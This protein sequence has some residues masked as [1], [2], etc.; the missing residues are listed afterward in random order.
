M[1]EPLDI[2]I[3]KYLSPKQGA[4]MVGVSLTTLYTRLRGP[5]PPP[6]RRIGRNW[7]LPIEAFTEWASQDVIE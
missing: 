3:P 4:A 7:L 2:D 1:A 6:H 5:T